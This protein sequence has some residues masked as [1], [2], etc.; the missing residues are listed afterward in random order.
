MKKSVLYALWGGMFALCAGLGFIPEPEGFVKGLLTVLSVA[1]FIPPF[2][3]IHQSA[4]KDR[5]TLNLILNLSIASLVLTVVVL[6]LNLMTLTASETVGNILYYILVIVSS[7]MVCSQ[8]WA[9]GLFLWACL[10][11]VCTKELKK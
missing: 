2:L 9:L 5:K 10:M 11:I 6:V 8:Y 4:G 1:F 3:L 7:P